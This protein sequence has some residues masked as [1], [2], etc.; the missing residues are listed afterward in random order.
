MPMR[1]RQR[2]SLQ[3]SATK[4]VD[5]ETSSDHQDPRIKRPSHGIEMRARSKDLH[6]RVLYE[7]LGVGRVPEQDEAEAVDPR[8]VSL[9]ERTGGSGLLPYE[10]THAGRV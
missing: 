3:G 6:K 5:R 7:V 1:Q 4:E 8:R 10:R 2:A 9:V